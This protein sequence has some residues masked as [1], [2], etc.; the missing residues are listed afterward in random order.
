MCEPPLPRIERRPSVG[1]QAVD[2]AN[3]SGARGSS[4]RAEKSQLAP[5]QGT[6]EFR[7][8]VRYRVSKRTYFQNSFECF[9][10]LGA[11]CT[12]VPGAFKCT[13]H[14]HCT[15]WGWCSSIPQ[16]QQVADIS[17]LPVART[18]PESMTPCVYYRRGVHESWE[19]HRGSP[20]PPI[21]SLPPPME[22]GELFCQGWASASVLSLLPGEGK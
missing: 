6:C 18:Q 20:L 15:F 9:R 11:R 2:C 12:L 1:R 19:R 7:T 10:C 17:P 22:V 5:V 3:G 21:T 14:C 13:P 16:Y 8:L 4:L